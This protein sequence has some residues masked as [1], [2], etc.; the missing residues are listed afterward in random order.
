MSWRISGGGQYA[1][2]MCSFRFSPVPTP[3]KNRPGMRQEAVAAAWATIAGCMRMSGHVTP[4]P[5]RIR[6]V[7]VAIAPSTP[8]TKGELPWASSQGWKWSEISEKVKP[9]A[10]ASSAW[11]TRSRGWVLFARQRVSDLDPSGS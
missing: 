1:P 4:V 5:I 2:V 8:Q 10:S 9:R 11:A 6:R 7:R 3:R